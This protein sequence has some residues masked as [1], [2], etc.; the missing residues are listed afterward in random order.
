MPDHPPSP[1]PELPAAVVQACIDGFYKLTREMTWS[2]RK[3]RSELHKELAQLREELNATILPDDHVGIWS[4][5]A[6]HGSLELRNYILG[7][8]RQYEAARRNGFT[9]PTPSIGVHDP[10]YFE[11]LAPAGRSPRPGL[12]PSAD[13]ASSDGNNS[14]PLSSS[15]PQ[16][17]PTQTHG[18]KKLT[19]QS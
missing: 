5:A 19:D 3:S 4:H 17:P 12:V 16:S 14:E 13:G 10:P 15:E 7:I 8:L 11:L 18:R 2:V 9:W 1:M 6:Q